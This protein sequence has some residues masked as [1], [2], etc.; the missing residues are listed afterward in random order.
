MTTAEPS[1]LKSPS[2]QR[3]SSFLPDIRFTMDV[4]SSD[5]LFP[6]LWDPGEALIRLCGSL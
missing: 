1:N 2:F 6:F 4:I 5:R 3:F